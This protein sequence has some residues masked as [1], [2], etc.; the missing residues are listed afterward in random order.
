[1]DLQIISAVYGYF[2][3]AGQTWIDL[4]DKVKALVARGKLELSADNDFAGDD[5]VPNI[6]KQMRVEYMLNGRQESQMADENETLDL[7]AGAMVSR[8]VYG[9]VAAP[10]Q[11]VDLT[12]RLAALIH[13][14]ELNLRADNSLAG[15]DPA[16]N[17]PK[18]LRVAYSLN[19]AAKHVTVT[20]NETLTLPEPGTGLDAPQPYEIIPGAHGGEQL[21]AFAAGTYE[22]QTA[23]GGTVPVTVAPLP[24]PQVISGAWELSFPPNWGA[25]EKVTLDRLMSW[26]DHTNAGV[27]YFS[28]TAVYVRELEIPAWD[29]ITNREVW[30]DLGAVKNFAEV[31]L[32]GKSFG[33]LWKPPFRVNLTAA[34]RPG[35][36]SLRVKVTNLWP[37]RLIG[38][39]QLP[40]D[41]EWN[42]K[43]LKAWPQWLLDGQPSPAG[44]VT[45][46]TWHHW[47]K[48]EA[49]RESGLLGPVML[50][51]AELQPVQ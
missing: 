48:D 20:E 34:A 40:A 5:P 17:T 11:T 31:S 51:V 24:A 32:N 33:V 25:P 41:R 50:R 26:T 38:D 39:E 8:A 9:K 13:H 19:G 12:A 36:N 18:E 14:G 28:G 46:T 16:N 49:L 15:G 29:I 44:R 6:V 2:P 37:N 3:P 4:T 10:E 42:G 1:V 43:A 27:K 35:T 45:F 7:P 30:L 22:L 47:T 23:T 21:R